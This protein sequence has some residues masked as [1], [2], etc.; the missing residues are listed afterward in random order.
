VSERLQILKKAREVALADSF[1]AGDSYKEA[2]EKKA[3]SHNLKEGDYA[4]LD[5]QLFLGK[6]KIITKMDQA[7]SG[8]E[9]H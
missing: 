2:H 3:S 6:K 5:N 8:Q 9:S 7:L 4:Y 1:K